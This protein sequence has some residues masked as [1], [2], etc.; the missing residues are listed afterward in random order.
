MIIDFIGIGLIIPF[1][2]FRKNILRRV[3]VILVV[4]QVNSQS[5]IE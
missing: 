3:V 1:S 2:M 4:V 5:L